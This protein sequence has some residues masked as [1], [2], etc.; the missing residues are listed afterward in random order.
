M[1]THMNRKYSILFHFEKPTRYQITNDSKEFMLKLIYDT[2][3]CIL[4]NVCYFANL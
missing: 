4:T 2:M 3:Q 1:E